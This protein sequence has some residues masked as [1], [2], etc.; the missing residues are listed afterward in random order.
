MN[1]DPK[2]NA[3]MRLERSTWMFFL[4]YLWI[5]VS[6]YLTDYVTKFVDEPS[7]LFGIPFILCCIFGILQIAKLLG[8][9]PNSNITQ[10]ILDNKKYLLKL[11]SIFFLMD[12]GKILSSADFLRIIGLPLILVIIP[13]FKKP[14]LN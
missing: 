4:G 3:C 12:H 8:I 14:N 11:F 13:L 1:L 2:N 10:I 5:Y 9:A 7:A 6:L